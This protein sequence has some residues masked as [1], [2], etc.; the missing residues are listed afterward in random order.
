MN[1]HF[2]CNRC[3]CKIVNNKCSNCNYEIPYKNGVYNYTDDGNIRLGENGRNYIG[4]DE[5]NI[6]FEPSL[7]YWGNHYGVY[8]EAGNDIVNRLGKNIIVLDLGCGLGTGT[9]PLAQAGATVIGADISSAMLEYAYK[10]SEGKYPNIYFCKMNAYKLM[11]EDESV[12]VII[13]NAMIHLVD[14]P[15]RVYQEIFRVLKPNGIFVHYENPNMPITEE[16]AIVSKSTYM[17]FD[18]IRS[19]YYDTLA[20]LGYKPLY[21]DNKSR[22]IETNYFVVKESVVCDYE[23]EFTEYM[24]FRI[25]RLEHKAHSDLQHIPNDIHKMIWDKTNE[26]AKVKYGEVYKNMYNY[27]KYKAGYKILI[28]KQSI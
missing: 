15:E 28:K 17:A 2:L 25:H 13:E 8:W 7:I 26:Y 6:H 21:F 23:E 20:S 19:F 1:C 22:E 27:A 5:I 12:D 4:Y 24:K 11:L 3:G 9:I 18:D 14:N 10:R 16:Q